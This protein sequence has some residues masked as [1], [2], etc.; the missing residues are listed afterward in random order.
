MGTFFYMLLAFIVG[1]LLGWFF[2]GRLRSELDGLRA[3]LESTCSERDRLKA[4]TNRLNGEL[5]AC[6]SARADLE[7]KLSR[8]KVVGGTAAEPLQAP[9][10]LMSAPAPATSA[11]PPRKPAREPKIASA[12]AS[13]ARAKTKAAKAESGRPRAA[14]SSGKD[15]LRRLVGIGPVNERR[16]NEHGITTFAQ[17]AADIKKAEEYLQFD[18]RIERERWVAQAK[19]LAAGDELEFARRFSKAARS[20]NV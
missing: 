11:A 16:L 17:I 15:D 1:L 14:N 19:L 4:D 3:N 2:W 13:P 6:R 10:A 9:A 20:D 12:T 5:E 7:R 18:G 8:P